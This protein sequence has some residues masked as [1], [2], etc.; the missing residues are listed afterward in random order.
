MSRFPRDLPRNRAIAAFESLGFRLVRIGSHIAMARTN[1]DGTTTTLTLPN[2]SRIKSSTLRTI[3]TQA[4][5]G[6]EDF[7]QA[8]RES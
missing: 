5:V 2:H 1:D 6:R 3:C 8:T 7:L 4:G